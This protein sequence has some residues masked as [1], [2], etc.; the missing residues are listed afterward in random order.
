LIALIFLAALL[1]ASAC[2]TASACMQDVGQK[3]MYDMRKEIFAHLQRCDELLRP[4]PGGA[5]G[6]ARDT[7]VDALN[8][9]LL[10]R[11]GMPTTRFLASSW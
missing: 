2:S 9:C 4:Q 1:S 10:P 7:D 3:T 5:A 8:D 6:D 11:R